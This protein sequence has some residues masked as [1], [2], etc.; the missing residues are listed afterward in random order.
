[1]KDIYTRIFLAV[2]DY[3]FFQTH[4]LNSD[5]WKWYIQCVGNVG[6]WWI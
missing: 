2:C 1:M 4:I 6:V 5:R 3:V